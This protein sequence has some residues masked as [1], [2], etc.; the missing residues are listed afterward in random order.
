MGWVLH[1]YDNSIANYGSRLD[2]SD[3]VDDFPGVS[4]IYLRL[5]WSYIQP[6][7]GRFN[8]SIIDTPWR[9]IGHFARHATTAKK[10][11]KVRRYR[12]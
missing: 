8:W 11:K 9:S 7:E 5:A 3:T 4:V 12:A 10:G 1:H 2:P 6:E